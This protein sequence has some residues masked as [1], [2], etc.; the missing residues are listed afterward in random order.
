MQDFL[1]TRFEGRQ[2]TM[3]RANNAQTTRCLLFAHGTRG[4]NAAALI[5][6]SRVSAAAVGTVQPQYSCTGSAVYSAGGAGTAGKRPDYDALQQVLLAT[7]AHGSLGYV[8]IRS[9]Q[10]E[11]SACNTLTPVMQQRTLHVA[12]RVAHGMRADSADRC[13]CHTTL[14][15]MRGR[16]VAA[17]AHACNGSPDSGRSCCLPAQTCGAVRAA[18]CG[19]VRR[20]PA[21]PIRMGCPLRG[22]ACRGDTAL[23]QVQGMSFLAAMLMVYFGKVRL[24]H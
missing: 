21:R 14:P 23:A 15:L 10:T 2:R 17:V 18:P 20:K 6:H 9:P 19:S 13:L 5:R 8:R 16:T 12:S 11:C 3:H 22:A 24:S 7:A 4:R 1:E